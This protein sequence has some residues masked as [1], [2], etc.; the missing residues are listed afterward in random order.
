MQ[1][2]NPLVSNEWF[3][4][5]PDNRITSSHAV[6]PSFHAFNSSQ[7]IQLQRKNKWI[8]HSIAKGSAIC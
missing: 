2:L 4:L 8:V 6:R 5:L 1:G 7:F 3:I